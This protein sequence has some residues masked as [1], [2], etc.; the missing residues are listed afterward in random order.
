MSLY[1]VFIRRPISC[2]LP[3]SVTPQEGHSAVSDI[4]AVLL[5]S[6]V[7]CAFTISANSSVKLRRHGH[8][9][10][11][12]T[13]PL[14][15]LTRIKQTQTNALI[16]YEVAT[17]LTVHISSVF[18]SLK[19]HLQRLTLRRDSSTGEHSVSAVVKFS[20]TVTPDTLS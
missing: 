6:P 11:S 17:L 5:R 15:S 18:Q 16:Y 4:Q 19:D 14:Q 8:C 3:C 13:P 20:C 9:V 1:L 2:R 12:T 7:H 10:Y